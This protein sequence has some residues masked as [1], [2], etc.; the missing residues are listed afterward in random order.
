MQSKDTFSIVL[1]GFDVLDYIERILRLL[2]ENSYK[3]TGKKDIELIEMGLSALEY[4]D[5]GTENKK[6]LEDERKLA[7][8]I[9]KFILKLDKKIRDR[10]RNH[11]R[12]P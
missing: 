2:H 1:E 12:I 11:D 10:V 4:P 7:K 3:K 5:L 8:E 9:T 6:L